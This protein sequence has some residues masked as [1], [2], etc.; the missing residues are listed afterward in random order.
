MSVFS[1]TSLTQQ[2]LY[3]AKDIQD[4][5]FQENPSNKTG[6]AS[7]S[8][9][10]A[11]G[12]EPGSEMSAKRGPEAPTLFGSLTQATEPVLKQGT[13]INSLVSQRVSQKL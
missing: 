6:L 4:Y 8:H 7:A 12:G 10:R 11:D 3:T 13:V 1:G 5:A 9:R 2:A